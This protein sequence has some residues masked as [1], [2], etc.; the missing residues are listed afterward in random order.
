[1]TLAR[2]FHRRRLPRTDAPASPCCAGDLRMACRLPRQS[3]CLRSSS[4]DGATTH[5][6]FRIGLWPSTDACSRYS[7]LIHRLLRVR[8]HSG[9]QDGNSA[10][11]FQFVNRQVVWQEL[12]D[13][14][15]F[16]IPL[17]SQL[18]LRRRRAA[19]QVSDAPGAEAAV[20]EAAPCVA[21]GVEPAQLPC[22]IRPCG[23]VGCYFCL[24]ARCRDNARCLRPACFSPIETL[25]RLK[26]AV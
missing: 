2:C 3:T 10:L 22:A 20:A 16:F 6:L 7:T 5:C 15:L 23:H 21:C 14:L 26:G 8:W 17:A 1:L 11:S 18:S 13:V 24:A 19:V 4:T 12:N 25:T 9:M